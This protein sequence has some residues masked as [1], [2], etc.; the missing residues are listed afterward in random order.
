MDKRRG[1]ASHAPPAFAECASACKAHAGNL[2]PPRALPLS[3]RRGFGGQVNRSAGL[4][5]QGQ[6]GYSHR[7]MFNRL[8]TALTAVRPRAIAQ[9]QKS[10][11]DIRTQARENR[12]AAKQFQDQTSATHR[13][14][15]ET[16][17]GIQQELR[18]LA[19][20]HRND[21][22]ATTRVLASIKQD[23]DAL[24]L[25]EAQLRA[26]A[27]TDLDMADDLP[28]LD[29]MLSEPQ[30]IKAHIRSSIGVSVQHDWPF[31]YMV[32]D[33]AL[34]PAVFRAL[35]EGLPP[36]VLF[37]DR[38]V[39]HQY[40]RPPFPLAPLYSRRIWDFMADVI[41]KKFIRPAVLDKFREPVNVWLRSNFP[42]FDDDPLE[43]VQMTYWDR[44][45][46]R[47]RGYQIPP[48]RDPKWAVITFLLYLPRPGDDD[49]W[50]TQLF[51]VADDGEARG[52]RPHWIGDARCELAVDVPFRPNRLLVFVNSVGAHGAHI[53]E[54]AEPADLERYAYQVRIGPSAKSM[55]D[56]VARLPEDRKALW[57]GDAT[58]D[59]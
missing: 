20:Q 13:A 57:T 3:P 8:R 43:T 32:V 9:T 33:D 53:P 54:D 10:I 26:V 7:R 5:G 52:V 50:G 30:S 49:R 2:A 48:H 17:S 14:I 58:A 40:L 25:R 31:P 28:A 41:V 19:S 56:L 55:A 38:P 4:V 21:V 6:A 29:A 59:Y 39:N 35:V 47:R 51:T 12:L 18:A 22:E 46:L 15:Q 36:A 27:H 37:G 11:A 24:A 44:L 23:V 45:L 42:G 16:L 34:P 1:R